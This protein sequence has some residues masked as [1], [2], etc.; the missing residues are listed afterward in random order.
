LG[1]FGDAGAIVTNDDELADK[2]RTLRNYG[3]KK[4]YHNEVI[5]HNSRLDPIQAAFLR[6]KLKYL[7]D[8]N[9]RRD[10]IAMHYMEN[11]HLIPNLGLP[12]V[13]ADIVPVWHL[14]VISHPD[15]DCLQAHLK[16]Q[17]I[18]TLI[19]YPIPPHLSDAYQDLGYK[20]GD[21]P[22]TDKMASTFLSIPMGPHLSIAEA[23]YVIEN[24]RAFCLKERDQQ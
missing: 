6:V 7:D 22:I 23:D 12:H 19:H 17:G 24:I 8:W 15:R 2:I 5:G 10:R 18:E 9:E 16:E 3:S 20:V 13:P 4:K 11:L 14:F 1:A 21:F